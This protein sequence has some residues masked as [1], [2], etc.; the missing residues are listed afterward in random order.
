MINIEDDIRNCL[1]VLKN[2]GIILYPTDTVWGLGCDATNEK[3]VAKIYKLKKR[4]DEKSM[5]VLVADEKTI[6]AYWPH[7]NSCRRNT[8]CIFYNAFSGQP[9]INYHQFCLFSRSKY[10]VHTH[11]NVAVDCNSF[12]PGAY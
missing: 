3:A 12:I 6:A 9:G 2:G 11:R 4:A 5:V 8:S 7:Y 1:A 10:L